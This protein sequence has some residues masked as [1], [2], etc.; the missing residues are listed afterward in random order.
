MTLR[1]MWHETRNETRSTMDLHFTPLIGKITTNL[2]NVQYM[3]CGNVRLDQKHVS[4][5][6]A[7]SKSPTYCQSLHQLQSFLRVAIAWS[8]KQ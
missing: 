4:G 2:V 5:G 1:L 3:V 8:E 7:D 6:F